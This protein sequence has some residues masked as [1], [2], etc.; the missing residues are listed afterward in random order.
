MKESVILCEL[1]G[2]YFSC[3][4]TQLYVII[5]QPFCAVINVWTFRYYLSNELLRFV[6]FLTQ[7]RLL[8]HNLATI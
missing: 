8:R 7:R 2:N 1:L 4:C 3:T 5:Y 6:I